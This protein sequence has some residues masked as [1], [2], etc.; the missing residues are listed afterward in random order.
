MNK[1][2]IYDQEIGPLMTKIV[3][4]C[5]EHGIAMIASFSIP[6]PQSPDLLCT[7]SLP[8]GDG[9]RPKQFARAHNIIIN[10]DTQ[11][12]A[13]TMIGTATTGEKK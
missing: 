8:D 4:T 5:Q 6:H 12:F 2:E 3:A 13:M 11:T 9:K 1:E 10:G 7:T